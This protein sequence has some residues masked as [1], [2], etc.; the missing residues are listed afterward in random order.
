MKS[1]LSKKL[2]FILC[3][4]IFSFTKLTAWE[5]SIFKQSITVESAACI[6]STTINEF[7]RADVMYNLSS[8]KNT[9]NAG[10]AA[11][12]QIVS[13]TAQDVF[14]ICD[15]ELD[16]KLLNNITLSLD[17]LLHY[18]LLYKI[19]NQY[20]FLTG[21]KTDL[22]FQKGWNIN[23]DVLVMIKLSEIFA[24]RNKKSVLA[25]YDLALSFYAGKQFNEVFSAGF[26]IS[27]WNYFRFYKFFA[28]ILHFDFREN[29]NDKFFLTESVSAFG[30]DNFTLSAL[31]ENFEIKIGAGICF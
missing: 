9:L 27:S 19:S 29:L 26:G 24:L 30:I 4:L 20:D 3:C 22:N 31:W 28:P 12:N 21:L 18:R 25:D 7:F 8:E 13:F 15:F 11:S 16:N 17:T 1:N 10:I 6:P 14:S 5:N 2:F 23:F